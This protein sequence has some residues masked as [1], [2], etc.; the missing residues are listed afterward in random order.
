MYHVKLL[1]ITLP[2]PLP[3]MHTWQGQNLLEA[4]FLI[5]VLHYSEI[6]H[7]FS[8]SNPE[9]AFPYVNL[10]LLKDSPWA[11]LTR[12]MEF[13]GHCLASYSDVLQVL[14]SPGQN[15][16]I[17][18]SSNNNSVTCNSGSGPVIWKWLEIGVKRQRRSKG[19]EKAISKVLPQSPK[20]CIFGP[21]R[22]AVPRSQR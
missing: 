5:S 19:E 3:G 21:E 4:P 10:T 12:E 6:G 9:F 8:G 17:L 11:D 18:G 2:L 22:K 16:W 1:S 14:L 7:V 20:S 13:L 15:G